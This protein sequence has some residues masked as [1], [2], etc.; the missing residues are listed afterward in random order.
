MQLS[1][2]TFIN[3]GG[4]KKVCYQLQLQGFAE[5]VTVNAGLKINC[6]RYQ[7]IECVKELKKT[8]RRLIDT[9][10]AIEISRICH[11]ETVKRE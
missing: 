3:S 6:S 4:Q 10:G 1:I 9:I 5:E 8:V 11:G 2:R 7:E